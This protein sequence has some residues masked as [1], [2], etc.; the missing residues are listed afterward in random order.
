[1]L[2]ASSVGAFYCDRNVLKISFAALDWL[3]KDHHYAA[4][5]IEEAWLKLPIIVQGV[6]LV[7]SQKRSNKAHY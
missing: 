6:G 2:V 4:E 5:Q 1:M 3:L 7:Q